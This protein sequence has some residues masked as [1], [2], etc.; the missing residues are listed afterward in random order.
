MFEP[1]QVGAV[2][3]FQ[4]PQSSTLRSS[5]PSRP[6][7]SVAFEVPSVNAPD[8]LPVFWMS[9]VPV[10]VSPGRMFDELKSALDELLPMLSVPAVKVLA[11]FAAL[12][13]KFAP[14]PTVIPTAAR[15]T[16]SAAMVRRGCAASADRRDTETA[17]ER[18][19]KGTRPLALALLA[20]APSVLRPGGGGRLEIHFGALRSDPEIRAGSLTVSLPSVGAAARTA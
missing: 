10:T 15:T 20:R 14:D 7:G 2:V 12:A 11:G 1:L 9:T 13:V 18:G 5:W 4:R 17:S 3:P 19:G 8:R 16:A 6:F